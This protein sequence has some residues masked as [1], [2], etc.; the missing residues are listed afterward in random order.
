MKQKMNVHVNATIPIEIDHEEAFR[1][2]CKCLD[3]DFILKDENYIVKENEWSNIGD[4]E[5]SV[6]VPA[7][8]TKMIYVPI[9]L[10]TSGNQTLR[11]EA[12]ANG[13]WV[14][15]DIVSKLD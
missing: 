2:L 14:A 15:R 12:E 6:Q 5:Q 11:I 9:E 10:L 3:M 13:V 7:K 4:Y 1:L 8:S